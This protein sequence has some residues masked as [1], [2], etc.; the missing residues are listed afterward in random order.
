LCSW[1]ILSLDVVQ[2]MCILAVAAATDGRGSHQAAR[3][4]G[5]AAITLACSVVVLLVAVR[6]QV[7]RLLSAPPQM[8]KLLRWVMAGG[9][10]LPRGGTSS[11]SA[12]GVATRGLPAANQICKRDLF[13]APSNQAALSWCC[14]AR[15]AS[16]KSDLQVREVFA[17]PAD[18]CKC[19]S[20]GIA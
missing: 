20:E 17:A 11:S 14:H 6:Q 15:L 4:A 9:R 16:S 19:S 13:A 2:C 18:S 5:L 1:A 10:A 7:L 12:P 3:G 8:V